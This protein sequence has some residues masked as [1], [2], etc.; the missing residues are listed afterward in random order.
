MSQDTRKCKCPYCEHELIFKCFEPCFC[1]PCKVEL[2][3]CLA[4][5]AVFNKKLKK[6]PQCG[7]KYEG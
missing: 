3:T 4:C 6:C 1:E 7:R 5:D 2:V